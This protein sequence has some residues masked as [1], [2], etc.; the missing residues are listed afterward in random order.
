MFT[1]KTENTMDD[2]KFI[3]VC[4]FRYALGRGSYAPSL[5]I[6]YL[7]KHIEQ[8][9]SYDRALIVR[10]IDEYFERVPRH[11][12][13][14]DMWLSFATFLSDYDKEKGSH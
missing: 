14:K 1:V 5:V 10:E 7:S 9:T 8:F 4:A 3:M 12:L 11:E 2:H 6:E 13:N